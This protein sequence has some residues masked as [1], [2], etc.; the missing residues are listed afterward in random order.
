MTR[1]ISNCFLLMAILLVLSAP[2]GVT[3]QSTDG[4][5]LTVE[6]TEPLCAVDLSGSGSFGTWVWNGVGYVSTSDDYALIGG[7][8]IAVPYD[9]RCHLAFSFDGLTGPG[10]TIPSSYFLAWGSVGF[11]FIPLRNIDGYANTV[12]ITTPVPASIISFGLYLYPDPPPASV[13]PGT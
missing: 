3:A 5:D 7:S 9:G 13:S 2:I 11:D 1:K 12:G 4:V 8:L 6:L 10:G